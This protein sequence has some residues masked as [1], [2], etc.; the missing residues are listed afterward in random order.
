MDWSTVVSPPVTT[1]S[2]GNASPGATATMSPTATSFFTASFRRTSAFTPF[3]ARPTVKSSNFS[4]IAMMNATSP[5]AN[6]SPIA[7]AATIAIVMRSPDVILRRTNRALSAR[8]AIGSPHSSTDTSAGSHHGEPPSQPTCPPFTCRTKPASTQS[9]L[10][11]TTHHDSAAS[12]SPSRRASRRAQPPSSPS[13][14][15]R[16]FSPPQQQL[17]TSSP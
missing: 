4:P 14:V 17:I 2:H 15:R 3:A 10:A 13:S 7:I 8:Y 16:A 1:P 5:A 11:A 12:Q 6:S 9:P